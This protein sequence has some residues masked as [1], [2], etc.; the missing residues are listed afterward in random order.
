MEIVS[1]YK[2]YKYNRKLYLVDMTLNISSD[3]IEWLEMKVPEEDIDQMNWQTPYLE[4]YISLDGTAKICELYDEPYP[5]VKPCRV[6]FFI[7]KCGGKIL[8]TPYGD[9]PLTDIENIPKQLKRIIEF[10]EED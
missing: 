8:H 4:Q 3:K 2:C 1:N 7:F 10:E 9:F 5:A 6:L